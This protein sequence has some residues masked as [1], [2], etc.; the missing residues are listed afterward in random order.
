MSIANQKGGFNVI[1]TVAQ[2]NSNESLCILQKPLLKKAQNWS[3]QI[4][5]LFINKTPALNRE[6]DEQLRIVP[7]D[8]GGFSAGYLPKDYIFTPINCYT[9]MEYVVQL[10]KFFDRFSFIFWK[11]GI[12]EVQGT[13]PEQDAA[14]ITGADIANKPVN[15]TKNNFVPDQFNPDLDIINDDPVQEGYLNFQKICKA[16]LNTDLRLLI[17]MEPTFL[18]NFRIVC[19]EHFATRLGFPQII[20]YITIDAQED[21]FAGKQVVGGEAELYGDLDA[22]TIQARELPPTNYTYESDFTVRELDDRLSLDVISTFPASQKIYVIDGK[23]QGEYIL[24]RF[25]LSDYKYFETVATHDDD[26]LSQAVTINET[27][28]AG[29]ENMT[30]GNP[31]YESNM[32]LSGSLQQIHLI[33]R[34]RYRTRGVIET[35]PT[36]MKDGFWHARLLFS[37]KV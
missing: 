5:D 10:Q 26:S 30:R 1:L 31:D 21:H 33:L 20:Y 9:I 35:V 3:L 6:L 34:T 17:T 23:E 4:T 13:T 15:Y 2:N 18:A 12:G 28:E 25:D 37:K 7:Y 16:S 11:Y 27:Y 8:D 32:L 19:Q 36:D 29:L 14:F 24:A 22:F